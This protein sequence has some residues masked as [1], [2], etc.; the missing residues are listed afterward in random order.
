ME[1]FEFRAQFLPWFLMLLVVVF[2]YNAQDD[3][4]GAIVGH[5]YYFIADVLPEIPETYDL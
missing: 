4:I 3:I 1:I 5:I 2:G